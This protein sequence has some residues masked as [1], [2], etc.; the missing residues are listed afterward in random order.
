MKN[1]MSLLVLIFVSMVLG[2]LATLNAVASAARHCPE[3]LERYGLARQPSARETGWD[4]KSP[5]SAMV[6]SLAERLVAADAATSE[7]TVQLEA[8]RKEVAELRVALA[9]ARADAST[10]WK[11]REA[12]DVKLAKARSDDRP[13]VLLHAELLRTEFRVKDVVADLRRNHQQAEAA[14]VEAAS[15]RDLEEGR[16][17]L[18][19]LFEGRLEVR[20]S[21]RADDPLEQTWVA[22]QTSRVNKALAR[23]NKTA[24]DGRKECYE[25]TDRNA[26][27]VAVGIAHAATQV[28]WNL[29]R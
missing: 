26:Q 9:L 24:S 29:C 25:R 6:G 5:L 13:V 17:A 3:L 7:L 27:R 21:R 2:I 8:S 14:S 15:R 12:L 11:S 10:A 16:K 1:R 19:Q 22:G 18:L 28:F 20:E 4:D 23:L